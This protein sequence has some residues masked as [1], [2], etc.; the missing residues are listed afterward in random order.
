[1]RWHAW[2]P[3]GKSE[4][5]VRSEQNFTLH[6]TAG[7][8]QIQAETSLRFLAVPDQNELKQKIRIV[9]WGQVILP[10]S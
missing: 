3:I 9:D 4:N 1:M 7:H 8:K 5:L 2:N 6:C 10:Q